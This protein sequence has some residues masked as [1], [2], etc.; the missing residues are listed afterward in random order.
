V[1]AVIQAVLKRRLPSGEKLVLNVFAMHADRNGEAFPSFTLLA[2]E[3]GLTRRSVIRIVGSLVAKNELILVENGGGRRCN[4]YRISC[5]QLAPNQSSPMTPQQCH[6]DTAGVTQEDSSS[7]ICDSAI[8]NEATYKQHI[9]SIEGV[10]APPPI[11]DD[12]DR[13]LIDVAA[14]QFIIERRL[15]G[16]HWFTK[17]RECITD[18]VSD[19]NLPP[20]RAKDHFDEQWTRYVARGGIDTPKQLFY[21]MSDGLHLK[22]ETQWGLDGANQSSRN[23]TKGQQRAASWDRALGIGRDMDA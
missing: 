13:G 8:R 21:F 2:Q 20:I 3:T 9:S 5:A 16:S 22:P 6:G 12:F 15:R 23:Q 18:I 19:L 7:D 1:N 14:N 17:A 11:E 4:T 10:S